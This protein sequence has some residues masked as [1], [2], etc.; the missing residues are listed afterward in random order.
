[1][2]KNYFKFNF[3][4]KQES[5]VVNSDFDSKNTNCKNQINFYKFL[6]NF[7]VLQKN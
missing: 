2:F 4:L 3:N 7:Q 1:M 5:L 6:E